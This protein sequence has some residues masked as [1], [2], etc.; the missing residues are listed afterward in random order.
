MD[1]IRQRV[2][3][4]RL[5]QVVMQYPDRR[6][7]M[8]AYDTARDGLGRCTVC[9]RSTPAAIG[10]AAP[11]ARHV[12]PPSTRVARSKTVMISLA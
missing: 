6:L 11:V 4:P 10:A 12:P 5:G 3:R 9:R 2:E 7:D 1:L 8:A